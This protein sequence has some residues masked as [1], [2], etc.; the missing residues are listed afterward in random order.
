MEE[1]RKVAFGAAERRKVN[2]AM[3]FLPM[4]HDVNRQFRLMEHYSVN[5]EQS[6]E[7]QG[8]LFMK[9]VQYMLYQ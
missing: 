1:A 3:L 7:V 2:Y 9:C 5:Q 6:L 4:L 8:K